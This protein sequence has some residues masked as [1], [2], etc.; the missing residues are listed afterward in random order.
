VLRVLIIDPHEDFGE[1]L[2][3]MFEDA[4][5]IAARCCATLDIGAELEA[6]APPV[7]LV[8]MELIG[9][10][11]LNALRVAFPSLQYMVGMASDAWRGRN[12]LGCN[13]VVVKPFGFPALLADIRR[14]VGG[15][16]AN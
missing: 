3:E 11:D 2:A 6:W 15:E 13:R 4:D 8:A 7:A 5:G 14:A 10:D 9:P 16:R 12:A 1:L